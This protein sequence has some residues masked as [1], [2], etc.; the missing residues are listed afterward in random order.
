MP[1]LQTSKLKATKP[2]V[3]E[4][5]LQVAV[6]SFLDGLEGYGVLTW[7][8]P[9][10]EGVRSPRQGAY[11][12]KK[13]LKPGQPDCDIQVNG[14]DHIHIELKV[15]GRRLEPNQEERHGVLRVCGLAVYTVYAADTTD[16]V[17]QVSNILKTHG[18]K[19]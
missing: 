15:K 9:Y 1:Y 4:D 14:G 5:S 11:A 17:N 16:A 2:K 7:H 18:V 19:L 8:H 12:K 6:A 10:N 13:G 3:Y